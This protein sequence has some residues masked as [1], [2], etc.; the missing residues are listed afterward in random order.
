MHAADTNV[1]VRYLIYDDTAQA[2]RARDF[3]DRA[4]V[5]VSAT[6]LLETE[7]VLRKAYRLPSDAVSK[8]LRG[9][10]RL[11]TIRVENPERV[12]I[13]LAW[14]DAGMDFADALHLAAAHHCDGLATF[15]R[16]FIKAAGRLG[17]HGVAEP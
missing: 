3:V 6:V 12:R 7:W 1:V 16:D 15:D 4:D 14:F 17:L 5:F 10:I 13:A 2:N 11:P 9:F 8:A